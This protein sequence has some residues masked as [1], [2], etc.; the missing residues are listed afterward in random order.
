MVIPPT[1]QGHKPSENLADP[2]L[3]P[4]R[5]LAEGCAPPMVTLRNLKKNGTNSVQT[6]GIVL[7]IY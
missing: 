3:N 4:R 7:V 6:R 2:P 5:D 1:Y